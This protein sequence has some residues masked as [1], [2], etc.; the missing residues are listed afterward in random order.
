MRRGLRFSNSPPSPGAGGVGGADGS[1]WHLWG[2]GRGPADGRR[3]GREHLSADDKL[4]LWASPSVL[5]LWWRRRRWR[6]LRQRRRRRRRRAAAAGDSTFKMAPAG[7]ASDVT[8]GGATDGVGRLPA[9]PPS[10]R[11]LAPP[12]CVVS[13]VA[14][15]GFWAVSLRRALCGTLVGL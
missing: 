10:C 5:L 6:S 4:Q 1:G 15:L 3:G 13:L 9:P 12:R 8:R 7:L 14:A 2:R 11:V